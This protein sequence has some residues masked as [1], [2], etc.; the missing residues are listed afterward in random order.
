MTTG[1]RK[2]KLAALLASLDDCD[3]LDDAADV[4]DDPGQ[5]Q[6]GKTMRDYIVMY[7]EY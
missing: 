3:V 1:D 6:P 7:Y 2:R 4:L 5:S